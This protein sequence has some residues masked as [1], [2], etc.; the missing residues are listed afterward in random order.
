MYVIKGLESAEIVFFKNL[1]CLFLKKNECKQKQK[2]CYFITGRSI[3]E[4]AFEFN[5][6]GNFYKPFL[7]VD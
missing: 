1:H 7:K 6:T 5:F 2:N 4:K 3:V